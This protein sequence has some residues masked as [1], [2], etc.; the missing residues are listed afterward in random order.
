MGATMADEDRIILHNMEFRGHH[1]VHSAERELGQRFEVDV[2]LSLDLGQ[3][4]VSDALHDSVDYGQAYMIVREEVEEHQY[5]LLEGLAGAI[6]R[7][8]M[9]ELPIVSVLVRVRKPQVP[10]HGILSYA[11]VEIQRRRE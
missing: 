11:A 9:A 7:R 2:E 8:L 10:I 4:L 3:A 1:G 6:V 5:Q